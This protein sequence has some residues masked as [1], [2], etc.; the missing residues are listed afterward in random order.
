MKRAKEQGKTVVPGLDM[1]IEQAVRQFEIWTGESAPARGD[2]EGGGGS[3]GAQMKLTR[4]Q[5]AAVVS[6]TAVAHAQTQ[7]QP[8]AAPADALQAARDRLKANSDA[9][10]KQPVPMATEPAFQF[11]A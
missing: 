7:S 9:L 4:R 1:F 3:A 10:A 8:A 6:A 5:L 11:K 2:A